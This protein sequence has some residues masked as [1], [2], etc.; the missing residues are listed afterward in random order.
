QCEG[1]AIRAAGG[2]HDVVV[3]GN[4]ID[5]TNLVVPGASISFQSADRIVICG[6]KII[7]NLTGHPI[8]MA[9]SSKNWHIADNFLDHNKNN[10]PFPVTADSTVI[11]NSGYN[12]VGPIANPW[13]AGGDLTNNGG[14]D[15]N[16]TSGQRY[17]VRQS[18]KTIIITGGK[19]TGIEIDG[20]ATGL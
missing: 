11:D 9:G 15:F 5:G 16:P 2:N 6:N 12:P 18:P 1:S 3:S 19:V 13:N 17:I 7:N 4:V 10:S 8:E 14:G 20:T